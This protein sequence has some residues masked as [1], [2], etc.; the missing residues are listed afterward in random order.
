[1]P[2]LEKRFLIALSSFCLGAAGLLAGALPAAANPTPRTPWY[3][4]GRLQ[5]RDKD[6]CFRL[7][8]RYNFDDYAVGECDTFETSPASLN[9]MRTIAGRTYSHAGVDAC[10]QYKNAGDANDC[11]AIIGGHYLDDRAVAVCKEIDTATGTN[12]CLRAIRDKRLEDWQIKRCDSYTT[13]EGATRCFEEMHGWDDRRSS[14]EVP[15]ASQA[16]ATL[17]PASLDESPSTADGVG[18]KSVGQSS[19]SD[20]GKEPAKS[21]SMAI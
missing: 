19:A 14:L 2:K 5:D 6:E 11:L 20:T 1:M 18:A 16:L 17:E 9:C 10:D 15:S 12:K 21:G 4:C 7:V 8:D 3:E 13:A